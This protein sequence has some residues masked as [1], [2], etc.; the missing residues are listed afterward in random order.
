MKRRLLLLRHAKSSWDD[1]TLADHDRPL[2]KRGCKAAALMRDLIRSDKLDP[3]LILVSS[4]KRTLETLAA[5]EPWRR[6]PEIVVDKALY[7]AEPPA[8]FDRLRAAP[9]EARLI[10]LI[11]HNP[12]L[13][14]FA[15]LLAEQKDDPMNRALRERFPTGALAQ[16]DIDAP[17]AKIRTGAGKLTRLISP[18]SLKSV[19]HDS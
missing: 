2:S 14:E 18:R 6:P 4:A 7:H 10:L 17:W 12:G 3:D 13:Q 16:F 19:A 11:G 5:L 1:P 15:T 9:E 8:L